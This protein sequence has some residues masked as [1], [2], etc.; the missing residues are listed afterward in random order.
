MNSLI[1]NIFK[2]IS[3]VMGAF[4]GEEVAT[5]S[6]F[7]GQLLLFCVVPPVALFIS[8]LVVS[9]TLSSRKK[10]YSS[11]VYSAGITVIPLT[12]WFVF[13]WIFGFSSPLLLAAVSLLFMSTTF[14]FISSLLQNVYLLKSRTTILI[15]PTILILTTF[16]SKLLYE[17]IM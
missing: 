1:S 12:A 5:T 17:V 3:S 13:I 11:C 4:G 14:I 15:T 10:D 2:L 6:G 8:Y 9:Y 16:A 7:N